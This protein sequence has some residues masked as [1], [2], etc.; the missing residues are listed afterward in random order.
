MKLNGRVIAGCRERRRQEER[1]VPVAALSTIDLRSVSTCMQRRK[2]GQPTP[3][4]LPIN[5]TYY[6]SNESRGGGGRRDVCAEA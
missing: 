3:K 2:F 1:E 4:S 6:G 5:D